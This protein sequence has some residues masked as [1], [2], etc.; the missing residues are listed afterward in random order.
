MLSKL[1]A[2]RSGTPPKTPGPG[3]NGKRHPCK[4]IRD[5]TYKLLHGGK[6]DWSG[7]EVVR[8]KPRKETQDAIS[9][10]SKVRGRKGKSRGGGVD[11]E[12][13][14]CRQREMDKGPRGRKGERKVGGYR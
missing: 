13:R 2:G 11:T 6:R 5:H 8:V 1:K 4:C 10:K 7:G 14:L 9:K 3:S 12:K